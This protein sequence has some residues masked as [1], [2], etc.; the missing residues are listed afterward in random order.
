MGIAVLQ[1]LSG[2]NAIT[3]YS[4]DIFKNAGVN[5]N[6]GTAYTATISWIMVLGSTIFLKFFGR[7]TLFVVFCLIL[8]ILSV[9]MSLCMIF[10]LSTL[11][12]I[13]TFAYMAAF[14]FGPGPVSWL[15]MA[16]ISSAKGLSIA[17]FV[18]WIFTLAIGILVE[19]LINSWTKNY[20]FMIFGVTNLLAVLFC[21]LSVKETKG[22]SRKQLMELYRTN[23]TPIHETEM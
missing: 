17:T 10:S 11:E 5:P 20:T 15:Y 19:P 12:M 14:Q 13:C 21:L 2:V 9:C 1:Q 3:F 6:L 7:K 16:E 22:K 18:C 8:S 4:A 23:Y